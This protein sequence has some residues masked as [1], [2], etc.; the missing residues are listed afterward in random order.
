[1]PN[2]TYQNNEQIIAL[3]NTD[4]FITHLL[5][6]CFTGY[7]VVQFS[8][9]IELAS[10]WQKQKLRVAAVVSQ[11]DIMGPGGV[12]LFETLRAK[13]FEHV[14]YFIITDFAN[15]NLLKIALQAGV[16][17]VFKIPVNQNSISNRV[18]FVIKNW[19][20]LSKAT[21]QKA[22]KLYKTP[23]GK[24]V[25]DVVLA[26]IALLLLSPVF[27]LIIIALKIE[28]RGPIF[29]Y[30]LRVGTGYK[31]FKFYKFRSMYVNADKKFKELTSLNQY[32]NGNGN[33]AK[34]SY[35]NTVLC[36]DCRT[37]GSCRRLLYADKTSW[38]EKQY[39]TLK[40]TH[41]NAAFFKFKD[42]PRITKVGKILRNTSMDELPQLFNVLK[43]DMSI[44]GN[45]P[46]PMYE[47]EKLTTDKYAL[48]FMAPAGITGLWQVKKRGKDDM[49]EEERL[50][51]DNTYAKSHSFINDIRL[52][53]NTIPALFQKES[54]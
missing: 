29:Y 24:R 23:I 26:C 47:A 10:Y 17:D 15:E 51:L 25:F 41:A 5:N 21:A 11:S 22:S 2:P 39:L 38:C 46:L 27:L 40:K 12:S 44:V 16:T 13:D 18:L 4:A 3:V 14:P 45:R 37:S 50:L 31:I 35:A 20:S 9:G 49:S 48:R 53:V 43:G 7:N 28:S 32:Q 33:S 36:G 34:S 54:V 52:I 30:S 42:D 19:E 6:E 8:N 1:M